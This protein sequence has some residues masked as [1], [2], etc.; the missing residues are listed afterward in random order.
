MCGSYYAFNVD[1]TLIFPENKVF[2]KV[3]IKPI[4]K[5]SK[6]SDRVHEDLRFIHWI[7]DKLM[8]FNDNIICLEEMC[9]CAVQFA[10]VSEDG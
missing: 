7:R 9:M 8:F 3:K 2:M 1:E 4:K 6:K 5:K 10:C